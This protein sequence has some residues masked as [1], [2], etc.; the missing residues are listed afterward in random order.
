MSSLVEQCSTSH[1]RKTL[2]RSID[3]IVVPDSLASGMD[4]PVKADA[5][6]AHVTRFNDL[7]N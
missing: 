5:I 4:R 1:G 2:M 6:Q 7:E 3:D